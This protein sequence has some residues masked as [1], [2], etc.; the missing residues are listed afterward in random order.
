M[1][2]HED[3]RHVGSHLRQFLLELEPA[4]ARQ[5][6][7]EH[8]AGSGIRALTLKKF[9]SGAEE[10]N[11]KTDRLEQALQGSTHGMRRRR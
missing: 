9:V 11:V 8:E 7:V 10:L 6:D 2:G 3:D 4:N 5:P 1:P